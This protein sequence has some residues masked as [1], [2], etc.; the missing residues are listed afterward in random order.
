MA[1]RKA[2]QA[3]NSCPVRYNKYFGFILLGLGFI[4]I[5]TAG[6]APSWQGKIVY[7]ENNELVIQP[8][9][10]TEIKS[11]QRLLIYR[12]KTI[13]HPITKEELGMIKDE[14]AEV[15]VLK[16]NQKTVTALVKD[17]WFDM[18]MVD[19]SA[20]AIRGSENAFDGSAI[21][22]GKIVSVN[23]DAKTAEI[24]G[25]Y[26]NNTLT[27]IKYTD[28]IHDPDSHEIIAVAVEPVASLFYKDGKFAYDLFD[29]TLGWVVF[30]DIVV[31]LTGDMLQKSR[32][33][34]D[35]PDDFSEEMLY[36]RNY[37]RAIEDIGK[38]LYREA[39]LELEFVNR[40]N[41]DYG[42][43][44]FLI[45]LCY[46]KLNRNE[47]A[48]K[49]FG[50][51]LKKNK[52]DI[53]AWTELTYIHIRQN[54]LSD[55]I[56]AYEELAILMPNRSDIWVDLGDIYHQIGDKQK[57]KEAYLKALEIDPISAEA[58]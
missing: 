58:E 36:K 9:S 7:L 25:I 20:I 35:P 3:I 12:Q 45:G 51:Y 8:K 33:Y 21:E 43:L 32:W 4:F 28:A 52:S 50:E 15:S 34:Q 5:F 55:A 29:K 37:F 39:L 38:G 6:C 44:G 16:V 14:I 26:V 53:R 48:I 54:R 24:S 57:A 13:I 49:H 47:D 18:M 19:D 10:E 11:G 27:V 41:P 1:F 23:E 2:N 30:D 46:A 17:P 22:I 56:K 31:N 42:D 40:A